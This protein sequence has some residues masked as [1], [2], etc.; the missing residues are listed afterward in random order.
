MTARTTRDLVAFVRE[1]LG[2]RADPERAPAM[3]AYMKTT[4]PF[5]GVPA[6]DLRAVAREAA[7]RSPPA[8]RGAYER[9]VLAV[10]RLPNREEKHVAV[11][12]ARHWSA[13]VV[14]E[15]LPL[16]E[17]LVREGAWW[18]FV[19]EVAQHLVGEVVLRFPDDAWPVLDRWIDDPDMW[20][21]RTAILCQ[22]RHAGRT[23]E[24]RL[25]DYCLR[26]AGEREFFIRKAIGWAL[27]QY[28]RTAPDAVRRFLAD[29]HAE[30]SPLSVREAGKHL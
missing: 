25:F 21:R 20:V 27:R 30:L 10:W 2:E 8:D 13:F 12:L 26:R 24:A 1:R 14:P 19:D 3:Q 6:P 16:Y 23:D 18:D 15:S 22:N 17:R 5:L 7:R 28:A 9:S 4:M 11:A 29:H